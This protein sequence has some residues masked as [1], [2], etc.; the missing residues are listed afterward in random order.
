MDRITFITLYEHYDR[1]HFEIVDPEHQGAAK[2]T[3][4]TG[5]LTAICGAIA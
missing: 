2:S 4:H 1:V 5:E 3:N